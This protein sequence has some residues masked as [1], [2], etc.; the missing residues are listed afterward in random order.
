M[1]ISPDSADLLFRCLFCLIFVGLGGEHIFSDTLILRLMPE[2]VPAPRLVSL[3]CGIWLSVWGTFILVGWKLRWAA[4]A[5][6]AFL[7]VVTIAVHLPGVVSAPD[8]ITA[9]S[10]WLW[11]ILQRTNLVKNLCLLGVCFHLLHHQLGK[12]SLEYVLMSR[13]ITKR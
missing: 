6:G 8:S 1:K 4:F 12:Y 13:G 11:D 2:W 10:R 5:L 7:V 9:E 3:A